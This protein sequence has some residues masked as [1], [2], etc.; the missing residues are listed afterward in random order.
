MGREKEEGIA[1]KAARYELM[2]N[3]TKKKKKDIQQ[4]Q[5]QLELIHSLKSQTGGMLSVRSYRARP[6]SNTTQYFYW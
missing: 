5:L 1:G 6:K 3:M 4:I 2:N